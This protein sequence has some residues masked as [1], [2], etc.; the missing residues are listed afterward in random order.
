MTLI[1]KNSFKTAV[2]LFLCV[3]AL[4]IVCS[5]SLD[6][7]RKKPIAATNPMAVL[8]TARRDKNWVNAQ[9]EVYKTVEEL[10]IQHNLEKQRKFKTC[11]IMHGDMTKKQI[12]ITFD[13]GPHPQF[14]PQILAILKRY[15][16][17]A[18]FF[19]V[20]EKALQYPQLIRDEQ[21]A[22]MCIGNHTYHHVN[23]TK[24]PEVYVA[25]E[26]QACGDA[27]KRITGKRPYFFR[28]PGGDYNDNV[29]KIANKLHY[30]IVLWTDDPG[31]YSSPGDKLI[32]NRLFDKADNGGIILIHDGVQQ[33]IN[34][35]PHIIQRLRNQG[36]EFVTIDK[37]K[38]NKTRNDK[39]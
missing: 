37:M 4:C 14:T 28:P 21:S 11:K 35:L 27:V 38:K 25:A 30:T 18:T 33:T 15:N 34:I 9:K 36:Y 12:A 1:K 3:A 6:A 29:A 20:G 19:V 22:G 16:V 17:K 31:D 13:D 5:G 26:I 24:I 39:K 8:Q 23:L 10:K 32:E 2:L 7:G